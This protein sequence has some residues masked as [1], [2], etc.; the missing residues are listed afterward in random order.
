MTDP[1]SVTDQQRLPD[2]RAG[3]AGPLSTL[4]L[5]VSV[6]AAGCAG[7]GQA[8]V[9]TAQVPSL[10]DAL[11]CAREE[12]TEM[13]YDVARIDRDERLLILER[14]DEDVRRSNPTFHRAVDQLRLQPAAGEPGTGRDLEVAART[15][16]EHRTREGRTRRQQAASES[17]VADADALL[18]RCASGGTAGR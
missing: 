12:G 4:L 16:H 17:V 6:W 13:G 5:A 3:A 9:R 18:E 10:S 7:G 2:R 15:Y 11:E 1:P 8:T 14:V